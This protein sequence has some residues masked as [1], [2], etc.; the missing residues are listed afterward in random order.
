MRE[1]FRVWGQKTLLGSVE[2]GAFTGWPVWFS[3][4]QGSRCPDFSASMFRGDYEL[5]GV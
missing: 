5:V 3:G 1:G 4:W 2:V